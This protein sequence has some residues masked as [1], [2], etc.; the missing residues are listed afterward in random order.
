MERNLKTKVE[1]TVA[2]LLACTTIIVPQ[3]ACQPPLPASS[4]ARGKKILHPKGIFVATR[5]RMCIA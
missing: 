3:E 1:S 2:G 5:I 4:N